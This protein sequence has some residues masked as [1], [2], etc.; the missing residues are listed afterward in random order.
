MWRCNVAPFPVDGEA[1][2]AV[3]MGYLKNEKA[4]K[5]AFDQDLFW[6]GD[7]GVQHPDGRVEL[8]DRAKDII[9]SGGENIRSIEVEMALH[10]H[11]A[12][13]HAAVV[14]IEDDY[15]GEVPCA[16]VQKKPG[17]EVGALGLICAQ[18]LYS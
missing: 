2:N 10:Q 14:A 1:G 13:L 4:T 15:W 11:E 8:K 5:E 16:V 17:K 7:L 6:T 12:V 3:M 9:I 18:F